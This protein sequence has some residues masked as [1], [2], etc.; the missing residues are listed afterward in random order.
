MIILLFF[1][2]IFALSSRLN[3]SGDYC[4]DSFILFLP[5][6]YRLHLV[7]NIQLS[8]EKKCLKLDEIILDM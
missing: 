8:S 6:D 5:D 7:Y 1:I 2:K 3:E 4:S